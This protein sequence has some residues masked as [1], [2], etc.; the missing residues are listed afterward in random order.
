LDL[1]DGL[2]LIFPDYVDSRSSLEIPGRE[3]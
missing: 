3:D 2:N 1:G